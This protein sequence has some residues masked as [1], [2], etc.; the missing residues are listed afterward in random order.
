[1]IGGTRA[2]RAEI[3]I[4]GRGQGFAPKR[5]EVPAGDHEILLISPDGTRIGPH[6]VHVDSGHTPSAPAKWIVD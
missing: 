5:L 4:D 2:Q 6:V 3:R 1:V